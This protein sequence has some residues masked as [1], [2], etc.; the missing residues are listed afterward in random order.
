MLP[1]LSIPLL[2]AHLDQGISEALPYPNTVLGGFLLGVGRLPVPWQ[3]LV[4]SIGIHVALPLVAGYISR[5]TIISSK[6]EEWF[7]E[8]LKYRHNMSIIDLQFI[9]C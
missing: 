7:N 8:L 4:P 3:A 2:H 1:Q 5:K 9:K 6:G